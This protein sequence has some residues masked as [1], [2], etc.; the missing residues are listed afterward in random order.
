[1]ARV[2]QL[3]HP[4]RG[5]LTL[6][7]RLP[8]PRLVSNALCKDFSHSHAPRRLNFLMVVFGQFLDHDIVLTPS[9]EHQKRHAPFSALNKRTTRQRMSFL[10]SD[11]LALPKCCDKEYA[12]IT[13]KHKGTRP[14]NQITA[15]VDASGI[16]GSTPLRMRALRSF[17]HGKLIMSRYKGHLLLPRNSK[18]HLFYTLDN[19]NRADDPALFAAGDVRANE[20]P[21]LTSLHTIFVR[22]HNRVCN[23]LVAALS[24]QNKPLQSDEWL[25][26]QA[27]RVVMAQLQNIVYNEFLPAVLGESA[28][29]EYTGYDPKIDATMNLLFT[30]AAYRWGHSAVRNDLL[31]RDFY[32]RTYKE[33][34]QNAFFNTKLFETVGVEKWLLG[35]MH[36]RAMDVDLEHV[37]S[38]RDFLFSPKKRG[39]LD[40]VALNIQRGRDHE[41]P[42]YL[43]AR[44]LY[45]LSGGL[46]DIP[47]NLQERIL[48]VYRKPH[49]IDAFVGGLAERKVHG[50]LLG[51]LLHKI[52]V[53]QF[54]RLRNGDRFFY[55]NMRWGKFMSGLDIVKQIQMHEV[56]LADI[57]QLN[58]RI[59]ES[60]MP[61]KD[62]AMRVAA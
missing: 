17:K 39:T 18:R 34:F 49:H 24:N 16:Y 6:R 14:F 38:I 2:P 11:I 23:L 12:I 3:A 58:T 44:K 43:E 7:H 10:R 48:A 32:G 61:S 57:V 8:N 13:A 35:A 5:Q 55:S 54:L 37:D 9:G 26:Q 33:P 28:L 29:P 31:V 50:S 19:A 4:K 30:T 1:M 22:E 45:G 15:F 53:D 40:L 51:P 60:H 25:F 47:K 59:K 52:V 27:R 36:S 21:V 46:E 56:R 20:N 41:L 42:C 62:G